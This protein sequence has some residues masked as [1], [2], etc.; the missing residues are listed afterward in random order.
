MTCLSALSPSSQTCLTMLIE[1]RLDAERGAHHAPAHA[2]P[3]LQR[4]F[5]ALLV[6][7]RSNAMSRHAPG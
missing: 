3:G 6:A 5:A 1:Y 4:E 7:A 2:F